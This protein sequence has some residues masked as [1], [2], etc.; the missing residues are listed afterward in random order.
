MSLNTPLGADCSS[1]PKITKI[2]VIGGG[3]SSQL[4]LEN[5]Q[6]EHFFVN[7]NTEFVVIKGAYYLE[8]SWAT[9]H[10]IVEGHDSVFDKDVR[11][12]EIR[13]AN[14]SYVYGTVTK[15]VGEDLSRNLEVELE[16]GSTTIET[17]D[18]LVVATGFAIPALLAEP[19][20]SA[21]AR[22]SE[23]TELRTAIQAAQHVLVAGGSAVG[24]EVAGLV[25]ES[26]QARVSLVCSSSEIVP[27]GEMS[28]SSRRKITE[29]LERKG[30][31][32]IYNE[33]VEGA[34]NMVEK[35]AT[36]MLSNSKQTVEADVYLPVEY[37]SVIT[38]GCT[39][40]SLFYTN[41]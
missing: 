13:A 30:V 1:T 36:Y 41:L 17:F 34:A 15:V 7:L 2:I 33:R 32:L 38:S 8:M 11:K 9:P 3:L 20:V 37:S 19:G 10:M 5:L 23:L 31:E 18:Y 39:V 35:G 24:C 14:V 28:D 25:A 6:K 26:T 27:N 12:G 21:D 40:F 4:L 16:D 22:E 29:V